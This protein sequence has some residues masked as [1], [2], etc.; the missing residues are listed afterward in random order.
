VLSPGLS[1]PAVWSEDVELADLDGDG[2]LDVAIAAAAS[3]AISHVYLNDGSGAFTDHPSAGLGRAVGLSIADV[4]A[5]GNLDLYQAFTTSELVFGDGTG[6]FASI[7]FTVGGYLD[8]AL[9]RDVNGD[10]AIDLFGFGYWVSLFLGT[11]GGLGFH[12]VTDT[13]VPQNDNVIAVAE[14]DLDGDSD[15]DLLAVTDLTPPHLWL[16]DG[17]VLVESQTAIPYRTDSQLTVAIGDVNGDGAPDAYAG[18]QQGPNALYLGDAGQ[19]TDGSAGL[20]EAAQN[21]R[22]THLADLDGDGSLD[23]LSSGDGPGWAV[24]GTNDGTGVF[25]EVPNAMPIGSSKS[26]GFASGDLDGDGDLDVIT[27][28]NVTLGSTRVLTNDGSAV[29]TDTLAFVHEPFDQPRSPVLFDGDLDGDLDLM[30]SGT[31]TSHYYVGDGAGGLVESPSSAPSGHSNAIAVADVDADGDLDAYVAKN[32]P[33]ELWRN[34]GGV[35]Q[36]DPAFHVPYL[37]TDAVAFGDVDGDGDP[38][39]VAAASGGG[40]MLANDGTGAFAV[41]ATFDEPLLIDLELV[42]LDD[43]GDLDVVGCDGKRTLELTNVMGGQTARRTPARLGKSL[44][45]EIFGPAG[46]PWVLAVSTG[47]ASL[48][49]PPFGTLAIDP[50]QL[51]VLAQGQ[52]PTNGIAG[53]DVP[54]GPDPT[55]LGVKFHWQSLVGAPLAFTNREATT[56]TSL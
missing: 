56:V 2:D 8:D 20:P 23:I 29:F 11:P 16:N 54:L 32:D 3:G 37:G 13:H 12:E 52:V 34:T 19:W 44:R 18:E 50:A 42:D 43:D 10:G 39:I 38:D 30:T 41:A 36:L 49:L 15:M 9:L 7:G 24:V 27:T 6:S 28:R 45:M 31:G 35:F 14:A 4:D 21:A 40:T 26:R 33:D 22:I 53:V 1:P 25:T 5:D 47:Q 46:A 48:A 17:G 55:L 51:W